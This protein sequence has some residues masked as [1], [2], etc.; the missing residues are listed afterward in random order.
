[1]SV[2]NHNDDQKWRI[3]IGLRYDTLK[4]IVTIDQVDG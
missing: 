4:I 2:Q 3:L 1:M